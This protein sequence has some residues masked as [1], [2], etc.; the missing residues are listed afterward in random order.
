LTPRTTDLLGAVASPRPM[1]IAQP[2]FIGDAEKRKT[3][4]SPI[5]QRPA[6]RLIFHPH[7]RGLCPIYCVKGERFDRR[8]SRGCPSTQSHARPARDPLR[9]PA[10]R[11]PLPETPSS[12]T[13]APTAGAAGAVTS[14]QRWRA[15]RTRTATR[16]ARIRYSPAPRAPLR[17]RCRPAHP[18]PLWTGIA[19]AKT[20][21]L[22]P[23]WGPQAPCGRP[24][25][26]YARCGDASAPAAL[27][28]K[29]ECAQSP[30]RRMPAVATRRKE[31]HHEP[32]FVPVLAT[33]RTPSPTSWASALHTPFG[34]RNAR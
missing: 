4:S 6:N 30:S 12:S 31:R 10:L 27:A 23:G 17:A 34:T 22:P 20:A 14:P 7:I 15:P 25:S 33:I 1:V 9:L 21:D 2:I 3:I 24:H 11:S 29:G 19:A 13:Q 18:L 5:G 8:P 28:P 16:T 26:G 32:A